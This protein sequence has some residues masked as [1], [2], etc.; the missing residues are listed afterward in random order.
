MHA[1]PEIMQFL[2]VEC[3]KVFVLLLITVKFDWTFD[4]KLILVL[5]PFR[6][7]GVVE[8]SHLLL[9]RMIRKVGNDNFLCLSHENVIDLKDGVSAGD[10]ARFGLPGISADR[11]HANVAWHVVQ[12]SRARVVI[13]RDEGHWQLR[14]AWLCDDLCN[15]KTL[16]H[17]IE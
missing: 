4:V 16:R 7:L 13:H 15:N 9:Q 1:H 5:E 8:V 14:H 6:G 2:Q 17:Q 3:K 11:A 10:C 12:D